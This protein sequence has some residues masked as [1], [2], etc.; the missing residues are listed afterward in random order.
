MKLNT[1]NGEVNFDNCFVSATSSVDDILAFGEKYN[2]KQGIVNAG[3][4][5]YHF[6][7][8]DSGEL[9]LRLTFYNKVLKY[10][11]VTLGSNYKYKFPPFEITDD[12]K[13]LLLSTLKRLGGNGFYP[14]GEV[15]F[16]EDRNG[17]VI[18]IVITYN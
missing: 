1:L 10:I 11:S 13:E 16:D 4:E 15:F 5:S 8:I 2:L 7:N 3:Y 14:W 17:G 9:N 18:S 6:Y 12:E